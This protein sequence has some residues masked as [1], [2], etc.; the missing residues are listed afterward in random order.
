MTHHDLI[1]NS[2]FLLAYNGLSRSKSYPISPRIGRTYPGPPP[3]AEGLD[4]N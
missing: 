3:E 1:M 2:F 4:Q